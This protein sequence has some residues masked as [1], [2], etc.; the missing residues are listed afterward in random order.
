MAHEVEHDPAVPP[1]AEA[2]HMPEPS[3]LPFVLALGITIALV[4]IL[5]G[6]VVVLIGVII[7]LTV[8][9]RWIRRTRDEMAELPLDH[10]AH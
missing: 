2:I 10:S 8:I 5:T 3:Y 7:S 4:G 1:P 9:V 6:I